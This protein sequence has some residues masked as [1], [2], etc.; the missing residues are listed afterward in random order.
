M[1]CWQN[2][3]RSG[4][5]NYSVSFVP[6]LPLLSNSKKRRILGECAALGFS[7]MSVLLREGRG[8]KPRYA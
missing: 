7:S 5:E 4:V 3:A 6:I 8:R 1:G 2:R